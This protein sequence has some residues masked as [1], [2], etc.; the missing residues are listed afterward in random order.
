MGERPFQ[1][2]DGTGLELT[3][4]AQRKWVPRSL[5]VISAEKMIEAGL[6]GRAR[7]PATDAI[8]TY[9]RLWGR[10]RAQNAPL[11]VVSPEGLISA[12][13]AYFDPWLF[14]LATSEWKKGARLVG[15]AMAEISEIDA[16]PRVSDLWLWG[17]FARSRNK[18]F[19]K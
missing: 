14:R 9:R 19:W 4:K 18:G 5:G 12:P 10:L 1:V 2:I 16:S 7:P 8:E 11:R 17:E 3:D 13:L 6:I 15:E